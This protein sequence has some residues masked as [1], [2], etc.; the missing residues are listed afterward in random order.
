MVFSIQIMIERLCE[1]KEKRIGVKIDLVSTLSHQNCNVLC[2]LQASQINICWVGRQRFT[3][4]FCCF[5][6]TL[7]LNNCCSFQFNGLLYDKLCS[8]S[9][10]L[11]NLFLLNGICEQFT[12]CQCSDGDIIKKNM[13][14]FKSHYDTLLNLHGYCLTTWKKSG[15]IVLSNCGSQTLV[16][17]RWKNDILVVD[18][19]SSV[20]LL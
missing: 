10:L 5:G 7:S 15:C 14:F 18:T 20:D 6:L 9:C 8:L 17:N 1:V 3:N 19:K 13:V 11:G 12:E 4:L 16:N 2:C